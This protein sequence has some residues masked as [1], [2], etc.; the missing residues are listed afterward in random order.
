MY[1]IK[2][3]TVILYKGQT[4]PVY[5]YGIITVPVCIY[6]IITVP[7]CIYCTVLL[8]ALLLLGPSNVSEISLL[9][10]WCT[11]SVHIWVFTVISACIV[12]ILD[13]SVIMY[14]PVLKTPLWLRPAL[15][16]IRACTLHILGIS[17][18]MHCTIL[19]TLVLLGPALYI[20]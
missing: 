12:Y 3:Y 14:C 4:V 11:V 7:V 15:H 5:I 8:L 16:V 6:S 19:K 20:F 1:S 13:F 2:I 10:E 9:W 18:I 17:V